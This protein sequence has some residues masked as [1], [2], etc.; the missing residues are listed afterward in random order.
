MS[1]ADLP[2][3]DNFDLFATDSTGGLAMD[4]VENLPKTNITAENLEAAGESLCC[5]VC[6]QVSVSRR[7]NLLQSGQWVE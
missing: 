2:S 6:L 4:T 7:C 3:I 5:S 1:A